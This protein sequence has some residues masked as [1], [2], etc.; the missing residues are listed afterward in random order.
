MTTTHV[1]DSPRA[2]P[3]G[4]T[5]WF[6]AAR[7]VLIRLRLD[8]DA[9][10]AAFAWPRPA[11]FNWALD[12]FD[13]VARDNDRPALELFDP[14]GDTATVSYARMSARSNATANWLRGL[15]VAR[16]DRVMIVLGQQRELWECVLACLKLGSVLIPTYPN[17]TAPEAADRVSRGRIRH[18]VCRA[19]TAGRFDG[20]TLPGVRI[21]VPGD[22]PNWAS[23]DDSLSA[24][25]AFTPAAPTPADDVAFCYFTS[26]TTDRPKLVAHTHSS[27]PVGHLSSMYWNGLLPGDR[28]V[29]IS[30]PGWAKHSWSS[31]FVPWSAEATVVAPR[32]ETLML[33]ELPGLLVEL[34]IDTFCAPPSVWRG[35]RPY[36]RSARPALREALSAG[37]PLEPDLADAIRGAWQ[38]P[39]RDGYGQTETT[40]LVGTTPG[41]R[42]RPGWV[43]KPLPGYQITLEDPD[44]AGCGELCVD[45]ATGPVGVMAGYLDDAERTAGIRA[46]G[47]YRT[48][49]MAQMSPDGWIRLLGRR[50]EMFKSF[51]RRISPYEIESVLRLHPA[52]TDVAVVPLAHPT[53]GTVAQAVVVPALGHQPGS[54]LEATL[55]THAARHLSA[56]LCPRSVRFTDRLPRTMSGKVRRRQLVAEPA[57]PVNADAPPPRRRER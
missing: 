57:A 24:A 45:L 22:V 26:G 53:G 11:T 41:L 35:M 19:D 39:V 44:A 7:D 54:A 33:E 3:A 34:R 21:A 56:G 9:A 13:V 30:A 40:A 51:D 27:Y 10:R 31:L 42:P 50:D 5:E 1:P 16:G 2:D 17:L 43:G 14:N 28:H 32:A 47:R 15:G 25:T 37:E 36:L 20:I 52:V 46:G 38:V 18:L 4:A 8:H 12:W 49:D 23:Y 55:L 6:R 48:G 29:N